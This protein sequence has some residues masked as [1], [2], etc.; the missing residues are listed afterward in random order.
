MILLYHPRP[1]PRLHY[2]ADFIGRQL[3]GTPVRVT[4][5]LTEWQAF[6]G[7]RINY[8]DQ[9]LAA[10]HLQ[11]VPE[12]LLDERG[13]RD[14]E[15]DVFS[16]N[17]HTAF[18]RTT[19]DF[20]FDIL[21]AIFYLLSRYEE[22]RSFAPDIYGRFP[23][24]A[25][26]AYRKGFLD[27]PL[28][29]TWLQDFSQ[30]LEKRCASYYPSPALFHFAPTYDIDE[31]FC[32]RHKSGWRQ[33]GGF[34]RDLLRG[35]WE[36]LHLRQ[37]VLAGEAADPYDSFD[38]MDQL[39]RPFGMQ[40]T[41][42]ILV[43]ARNRGVDRNTLPSNPGWRTRLRWL[44]ANYPVG[45]HPSWQSGDDPALLQ[46]EKAELEKI[47]GQKITRSRQH[48]IRFRLPDTYRRLI[49]AGIT[50]DYSMGYGSING[51]RASVASSFYWYDLEREQATPLL[52]HPFCYMEAN[53][54]F[55]QKMTPAQALDEMRQYA[56]K[57]R[58]VHGTLSIIWHNT[59]LG[60]SPFYPGWREAYQA[61]FNEVAG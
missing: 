28:V 18:Y 20:P 19:G 22:Y 10:Q 46:Q 15:P 60:T 45:L 52:L 9:P 56:E 40:P 59:F 5:D 17:G 14:R 27:Q 3:T 42:F 2:V 11:L 13:I 43:A 25:S 24:T 36:Q 41:Y 53:S 26:L 23:H 54:F 47:T 58:R 12:G 49:D 38:W 8:S 6:E 39:H 35:Q 30:L 50:D 1:G 61:F 21:S 29:N 57:V 44:S 34:L 33:A 51:F 4:A 7:L 32:Y 31:A 48:F 16:C 55:E 37:R